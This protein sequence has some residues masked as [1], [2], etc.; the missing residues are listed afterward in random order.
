MGNA[1]PADVAPSDVSDQAVVGSSSP[2]F[3]AGALGPASSSA[4]GPTR[5]AN[6][7]AQDDKDMK[8]ELNRCS[9]FDRKRPRPL[10]LKLLLV[11]NLLK[12]ISQPYLLW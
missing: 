2:S 1:R 7:N 10:K 8:F 12:L 6:A 3:S 9:F 5:S 4:L 11:L